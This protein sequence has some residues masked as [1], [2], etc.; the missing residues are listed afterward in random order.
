[1]VINLA[2][3]SIYNSQD[4][5]MTFELTQSRLVGDDALQRNTSSDNIEQTDRLTFKS[6]SPLT[7]YSEI[8]KTLAPTIL[9]LMALLEINPRAT[10]TMS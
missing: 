10:F 8:K 7:L 5:T 3:V 6:H 1:M 2:T 4:Y 9:S